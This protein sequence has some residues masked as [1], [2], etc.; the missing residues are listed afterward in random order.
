M[1]SQS[2]QFVAIV[3][4]SLC[5][6]PDVYAETQVNTDSLR[7]TFDS[8]GNLKTALACFPACSGE[9]VR[10]Q[11]FGGASVVGLQRGN[12]GSWTQA[13]DRTDSHY[14]LRFQQASGASVS[15]RVP[16]HGHL[17]ELELSGGGSMALQ[18][19][20]SFRPR[21]ATG[22][23]NWLEQIRYVLVQNGNARQIS[24]VDSGVTETETDGWIG[25]RNRYWAL[26]V[27]PPSVARARIVTV[28]GKL[29]AAIS[30]DLVDGLWKF[31]LGPIEPAALRLASPE[32]ESLPAGGY[33][34]G[35]RWLY[36]AFFHLLAG[37]HAFVASWGLSVITMS[38]AVGAMLIPLTRFSQRLRDDV[39]D[40]DQRLV[41]GL[42]HI[43]QKYKDEERSEKIRALYRAENV[44]P[45]YRVK[46]LAG[47]VVTI[48]VFVGTLILL[49]GS[50]YLFETSFLWISDLSQPDQLL[51]L[52]F[53]VPFF[54]DQLNALPFLLVAAVV[55]ASNLNHP[56]LMDSRLKKKQARR[57]LLL[58]IAL[59]VLFYT[60]PAAMLLYWITHHLVSVA[61][62]LWVRR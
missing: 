41:S 34:F 7:L 57:I 36:L 2:C 20:Q 49:T 4:L 53:G 5:T 56:L 33:W 44:H 23:G 6:V 19:G 15:W 14:E 55:V 40:A 50:I 37:I 17:V 27:S 8:S 13:N 51:D 43:R 29:D 35:L 54:G 22:F 1:R 61:G 48:P 42:E 21:D 32:L 52:P 12:R 28:A 47:M 31:Y 59:F 45:M 16:L 60:L 3:L 62:G 11:Q 46:S 30:I 26:M 39:D 38:L 24:L 10:I 25:Y 9:Q 18:S 58:A